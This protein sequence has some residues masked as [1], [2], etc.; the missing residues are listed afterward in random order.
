MLERIRNYVQAGVPLILWGPPGV[1]KTSVV[2][3]LGKQLGWHV[4]TLIAS[5]HEPVDF[6]GWPV[7]Q[8]G[9]VVMAPPPWLERLKSHGRGIL[10][11]DEITNAPPAVQS[12]LL[13]VILEKVVGDE[14][15]PDGVYVL[16]AANPP[17]IATDG[18]TLRPP[19]ANRL[20]HIEFKLDPMSWSQNFPTYWGDPPSLP[21][22]EDL[23]LRA[24]AL[25]SA[26]IRRRPDMLLKVPED[27]HRAGLAWPSPRS[28]DSASRL[29]AFH[30]DDSVESWAD[31]VVSAVG[32]GAGIEFI[33]W[34][35]HLDLPD[36]EQVLADPEAFR[37]PAEGDKQF[38]IVSAVCAAVQNNI[39]L[40]RWNRLGVVL[41]RVAES[42]ADD[43]A[44]LGMSHYVHI[45]REL[46][47]QHPRISVPN[48]LLDL[49]RDLHYRTGLL[50]P[51]S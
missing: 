34:A 15:L 31:L 44:G 8:D 16:A 33:N 46:M 40:D 50:K 47:K 23:W 13:R 20:A 43:I 27:E 4:E 10:F 38:A 18:H 32:E 25:V 35:R 22:P 41:R 2:H 21:I 45:M 12:A 36:P 48:E 14:K 49:V 6:S 39:T 51:V 26:F 11:L 9:K 3:A 30:I 37:V 24:R 42:G 28:W 17:E 19:L 7:V 1:G 5:L 29:M